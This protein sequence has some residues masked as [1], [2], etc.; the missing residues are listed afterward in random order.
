MN[1]LR[2]HSATPR[3]PLAQEL[4][5]VP[6]PVDVF[7]RLQRLPHCIFLDSALRDPQLG[8]Y[9]FVAADPFAYWEVA[10]DGSDALGALER[11]MQLQHATD[12]RRSATVPRRSG[13]AICLRL[14]PQ[15]G[16]YCAVRA[17]TNF[18]LPALAIGLYDVVIAFDHELQ[19][20]WIVSQGLPELDLD[21]R[22]RR[23]DGTPEQ[24]SR[25]PGRPRW[26][27]Y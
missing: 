4:V 9:S 26:G 7:R 25:L 22:S 14:E 1:G 11:R 18:S 17:P 10:A 13:G 3:E 5:P 15:P 27:H 12:P 24:L 19:R 8:R 6:D 16:T 23:A 2:I 20:T 21:K